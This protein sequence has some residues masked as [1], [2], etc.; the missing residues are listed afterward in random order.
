MSGAGYVWGQRNKVGFIL[1][2][3]REVYNPRQAAVKGKATQHPVPPPCPPPPL[4]S[5][6]SDALSCWPSHLLGPWIS[7]QRIW[8]TTSPLFLLDFDLERER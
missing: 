4:I 2:R 7:A 6:F 1:F 8:A 3:V 5:T